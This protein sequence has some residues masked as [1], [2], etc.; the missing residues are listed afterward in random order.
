MAFGFP[1]YHTELQISQNPDFYNSV[2]AS[3]MQLNW[4]IVS[5]SPQVIRA[6]TGVSLLSWGEKF[7]VSYTQTGALHIQSTCSFLTQCFDWGKNK[8]CVQIYVTTGSN[9]ISK[10]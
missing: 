1:A 9:R 8:N 3:L 10:K 6:K 2:L 5:N 7:E 4:N